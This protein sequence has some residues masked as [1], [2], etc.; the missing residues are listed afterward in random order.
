M[1][2]YKT[3]APPSPLSSGITKITVLT[4]FLSIGTLFLE[5]EFYRTPYTFL[6]TSILEILILI[7][8]TADFFNGRNAAASKK[9]YI[10]KNIF[11]FTM[12]ILFLVSL[13]F[14][15]TVRI[16][17]T[18][19]RYTWIPLGIIILRDLS[20]IFRTL[21]KV[22]KL[23]SFTRT[24]SINP[25]RTIIFGFALG[26]VT[27][28][29]LLMLPFTTVDGKGLHMIDAL[30][31]A[32]SAVCVTG[33]VVVDTATVFT[34]WGKLIIMLLIQAGGI[35]IMA[36][37]FSLVSVIRRRFSLEDSLLA[38]YALSESDTRVLRT[39]LINIIIMAFGIECAGMLILWPGFSG[40]TGL[41]F[42]TLFEA[43]FHSVSAFC[44]AGFS[45][46]TDNL[47][48]FR[49]SPLIA[50]TISFLII[51]GGL[52]FPVLSNGIMAIAAK[53]RLVTG[54][55]E[56]TAVKIKLTTK[57]V[58]T[59]TIILVISGMF[60]IYLTELKT[61]LAPYDLG[62]QY[63]SAFFQSVT[64]RTA[65]FNTIPF[66]A[67]STVTLLVMIF[68][69]F[70][71]GA[72]GS[73]AGGVKINT[74]AVLISYIRSLFRDEETIELSGHSISKEYVLKALL[75]V[76]FSVLIISSST[77]LLTITEKASLLRIIFETVSAFCTVGLST[78]ITGGLSIAGKLIIVLLM[79]TGRLGPL[80]IFAAITLKTRKTGI[81]YP[82]ARFIIG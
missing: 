27:G 4:L 52:G 62:T 43:L 53:F 6:I 73:T 59:G 78:G 2:V 51:L 41:T 25:A 81:H 18:P 49:S 45:L 46:F 7:L 23:A 37:S 74:V 47:E 57:I 60:I 36:F 42:R 19:F 65:G 30:F 80:T 16:S 55:K 33:L 21:Q 11:S 72:S 8:V 5:H 68:F 56:N 69:M 75:I 82:E 22:K 39:D 54:R 38:S 14:V 64:L 13:A 76:L 71:G 12:M 58:I 34:L 31:T 35:G 10:Q 66:T 28:T 48:S 44:N 70:V 61:T 32:T 79:F 67:L 40:E 77:L 3:A 63:L 20:I 9:G 15:K 29:L 50:V 1:F 17:G 24:M 26:I